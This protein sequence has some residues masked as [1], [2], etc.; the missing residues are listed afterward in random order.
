MT[1]TSGVIIAVL[2]AAVCMLAVT[3]CAGTKAVTKASEN[4]EM[5]RKEIDEIDNDIRNAEE[6]YKANLTQLQME[7]SVDLRREVNRLWVELEHLRSQ[8]AALEKRL[9]ELEAE[10]K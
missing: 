10:S 4:P 9:A 1:R 7:E 8:K 5:I 2:L 6:M 3:G